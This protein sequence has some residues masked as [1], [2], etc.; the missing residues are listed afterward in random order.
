[1]QLR[2]LHQEMIL[3]QWLHLVLLAQDLECLDLKAVT[4]LEVACSLKL[5]QLTLHSTLNTISSKK[6]NL[7]HMTNRL[8]L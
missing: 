5:L 1:M 4:Y 8:M 6:L 2:K 7:E 3:N